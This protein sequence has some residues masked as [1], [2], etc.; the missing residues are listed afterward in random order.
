MISDRSTEMRVMFIKIHFSTT[1]KLPEINAN[2][3]TLKLWVINI[4]CTLSLF[5]PLFRQLLKRFDFQPFFDDTSFVAT[6][7]NEKER[8]EIVLKSS[9]CHSSSD[10]SGG[11]DD[12]DFNGFRNDHSLKLMVDRANKCRSYALVIGPAVTFKIRLEMTEEN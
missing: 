9:K 2:A 10:S 7:I 4:T 3:R 8:C 1:A 6:S 11:D 5:F 12:D